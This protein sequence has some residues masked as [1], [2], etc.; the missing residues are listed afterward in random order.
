MNIIVK[1]PMKTDD[2]KQLVHDSSR[3][4]YSFQF[5]GQKGFELEFSVTGEDQADPADVVKAMIKQTD[6]GKALYFSIAKK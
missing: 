3:E 6:Y 4:G 2:I 1:A 5:V